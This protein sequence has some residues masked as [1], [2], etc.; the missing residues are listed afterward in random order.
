V[1]VSSLGHGAEL[2]SQ[3]IEVMSTVLPCLWCF[4][5]W[6]TT[7]ANVHRFTGFRFAGTGGIV[8]GFLSGDVALRG[9]HAGT[10]RYT[11]RSRRH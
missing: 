3:W 6:A 2:L 10:G 7:L 1:R 5:G 8:R 9:L 4:H 11:C